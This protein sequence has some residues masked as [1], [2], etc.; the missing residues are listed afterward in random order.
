MA[1]TSASSWVT[2]LAE[3]LTNLGTRNEVALL[4]K[5]S[6]CRVIAEGWVGQ[7]EGHVPRDR[8][9]AVSLRPRK[10]KTHGQLAVLPMPSD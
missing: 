10:K 5:D 2:C 8:E 4:S 7:A 6:S 1:L 9:R 3:D